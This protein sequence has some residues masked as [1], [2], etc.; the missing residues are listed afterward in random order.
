MNKIKK[1]ILQSGPISVAEYMTLSLNHPKFGYYMT[2]QPFG[3]KGDF[4][5]SPEISQMFGELIGLW[6]LDY[7]IKCTQYKDNSDIIL[8]DIGAG[9]GTLISDAVRAIE[10]IHPMF[11][12][13]FK[14]IYLI[15]SSPILKP[16]QKKVLPYSNLI[17]DIKELPNN[18]LFAVAN[19][20]FDTL[21]TH[22][23][24]RIKNNWY[25]RLV[26]FD[27]KEGL[28][29]TVSPN[30]SKF[31]N[32]LPQKAE[33]GSIIEYSPKSINLISLLV[34][35]IKK[36]GGIILIID[37]AKEKDDT[38]GTI[39]SLKNKEKVNPLS[40]PGQIDIS[41]KVD[42]EKL[43]EVAKENGAMVSGPISQK[44]FLKNLGI[45]QRTKILINN[46][47]QLRDKLIIDLNRLVNTDEMGNIFKV[48]SIYNTNYPKP[49]G[50]Y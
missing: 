35:H 12:D 5:T 19:E 4:T 45:E 33:E 27:K 10:K 9:T 2:K 41:V 3:N 50:F 11:S 34:E 46:N 21:P 25:E 31:S 42:F 13:I 32:L 36:F 6:W 40:K 15:D 17:S 16:I 39:Q 26:G 30:I 7:F 43:S 1:H 23:F 48:I 29:Y 47:P 18:F 14:K 38:A 8:C 37:Y 24:L 20:F 44:Q 28:I 22:Q 49:D